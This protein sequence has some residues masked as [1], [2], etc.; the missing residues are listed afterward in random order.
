MLIWLK[1]LSLISYDYNACRFIAHFR[2]EKWIEIFFALSIRWKTINY[3]LVER[4]CATWIA[5]FQ[6]K[7]YLSRI[8]YPRNGS[9][10]N[11]LEKCSGISSRWI[12]LFFMYASKQIS[13]FLKKNLAIFKFRIFIPIIFFK[14][15][16]QSRD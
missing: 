1:Y 3:R 5:V 15:S 16:Q 2:K 6:Q 11:M 9:P 10:H 7:L 8:D 14:I 12:S 4:N 13:L